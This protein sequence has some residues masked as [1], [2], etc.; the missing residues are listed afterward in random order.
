MNHL[1]KWWPIVGVAWLI[2]LFANIL[3]SKYPHSENG[4]RTYVTNGS[5]VDSI[6]NEVKKNSQAKIL[7]S[8]GNQRNP[9]V[10]YHGFGNTSHVVHAPPAPPPPRHY[11]LKGTIGEKV[12][13]ITNNAGRKNIVKVGD[14]IDSAFVLSIAPNRVELKDRA[15]T[16]EL[17]LEK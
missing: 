14:K 13:T 10:D 9:F 6:L 2:Y 17:L 4:I 5:G 12:A 16:F 8:V 7:D 15:G 1:K 11:V 3:I